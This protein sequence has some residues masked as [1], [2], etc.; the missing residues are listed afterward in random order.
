MYLADLEK[1]VNSKLPNYID[2]LIVLHNLKVAQGL[3]LPKK[4]DLLS[5]FS[6][7]SV[8]GLVV[9]ENFEYGEIISS[10]ITME[11][12]ITKS[13]ESKEQSNKSKG[14][15]TPWI[16]LVITYI[17]SLIASLFIFMK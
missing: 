12:L 1:A 4:L 13:L 11:D 9:P 14:Y 2:R 15:A 10:Y 8:E 7:K 3:I 17:V 5:L 6:L 16:L